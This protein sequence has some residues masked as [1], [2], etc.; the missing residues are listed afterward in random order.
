[1]EVRCGSC[2]KL[3][4]VSDDKI[5]GGGIKFPCTRCGEYVRVTQHDLENYTKSQS[6]ASVLDLFEPKP[7]PAPAPLSPEL[8][9]YVA[10]EAAPAAGESMPLEPAAAASTPKET[11]EEK[12]PS[13][14][15]PVPSQP[16]SVAKPEPAVELKLEPEPAV[17]LKLESEPAVEPKPEPLMLSKQKA[18]PPVE[19]KPE[20]REEPK[21]LMKAEPKAAPAPAPPSQPSK[22]RT[23]TPR[24][25][26]RTVLPADERPELAGM[27]SSSSFSGKMMLVLF[28]TII[29]LGLAGYGV[30]SYLQR[31]PQIKMMESSSETVSIEGLQIVNPSGAMDTNG[32]LLVTGV[33]ENALDRERTAW[34]VVLEV[35]DAQGA[36]LSIIRL[37]NGNQIYSRRDYDILAKRG[38]N[39]QELKARILQQKGAV[40][41]P[42]GRA[43]FTA[44]YVQPP[45]GISSFVPQLVP[46]DRGKLNKEIAEEIK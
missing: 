16:A 31:S 10:G 4:R 29:A 21:P 26:V 25:A 46:F 35:Y 17:E 22:P 37:L 19:P 12:P 6:T 34:Y 41:P 27:A 11:R 13:F 5:T 23:E 8:D 3:F 9:G 43:N 39:V 1:M 44:R 40:I 42:K 24:P 15:E 36:V 45:A 32:D 33:I 18:E 28:G 14:F 2:K 38:V 7:G 30:Y 20:P